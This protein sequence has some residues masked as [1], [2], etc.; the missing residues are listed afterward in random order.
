MTSVPSP[1][2]KMVDS[3]ET[4]SVAPLDAAY[5]CRK[6]IEKI[7]Y[8]EIG[9]Q[10]FE[11]DDAQKYDYQRVF[12]SAYQA[13]YTELGSKVVGPHP[14][15]ATSDE[16]EDVDEATKRQ[17]NLT[18]EDDYEFTLALKFDLTTNKGK[19]SLKV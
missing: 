7:L 12:E 16:N 14:E 9:G 11:I 19:A 15:Q 6:V 3:T 10:C 1:T 4:T 13:A 2:V 17:L 8:A 18:S 5:G